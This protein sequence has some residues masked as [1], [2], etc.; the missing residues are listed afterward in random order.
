MKSPHHAIVLSA[1]SAGHLAGY[2]AQLRARLVELAE[3]GDP[4]GLASVAYTLQAGRTPMPHRLAI[5]TDAL[6]EAIAALDAYLSRRAHP[7]LAIGVVTQ[8]AIGT[9]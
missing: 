8:P 2:A 9:D 3:A 5:V 6:A 4:T 7:A 1:S